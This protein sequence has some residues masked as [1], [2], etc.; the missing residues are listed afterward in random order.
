MGVTA[1]QCWVDMLLYLHRRE[2]NRST[3][4]NQGRLHPHW[5][6]PSNRMKGIAT[7]RHREP[8]FFPSSKP[9]VSNM[10]C[11][12]DDWLA[13]SWSIPVELEIS[14][15]PP[16]ARV[17]RLILSKGMVVYIGESADLRQRLKTHSQT[18]DGQPLLA[19]WHESS[20][21]ARHQL[22]ELESDLMGGCNRR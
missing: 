8:V 12:A 7:A 10:D 18:Y 20:S 15:G 2:P 4:N 13:M 9:A 11:S 22:H 1:R 14:A 5:T 19:S 17:Y 3:L 16:V 21:R 6:H